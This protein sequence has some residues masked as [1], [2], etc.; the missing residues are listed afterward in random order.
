[1]KSALRTFL[2]R[3]PF[4]RWMPSG[5]AAGAVPGPAARGVGRAPGSPLLPA[6]MMAGPA[7]TSPAHLLIPSPPP[8]N[9]QPSN[10]PL[11]GDQSTRSQSGGSQ[12]HGQE[13]AWSSPPAEPDPA[14]DEPRAACPA[15]GTPAAGTA[16]GGAAAAGAARRP[17]AQRPTHLPTTRRAS[18]H[19][20]ISPGSDTDRQP[21]GRPA[22]PQPRPV[23]VARPRVPHRPSRGAGQVR[24][25]RGD[26][27]RG[28]VHPAAPREVPVRA[29]SG[30]GCAK[31]A[32]RSI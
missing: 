18:A 7:V 26:G 19:G 27:G 4:A 13:L 32:G 15:A 1:M 24:P 20:Q 28:R 6:P 29:P 25:G 8:R 11:C 5:M 9:S 3:G 14:A 2:R 12:F 16:A 21:G 22:L 23:A 10:E 30:R 17:T 31:S